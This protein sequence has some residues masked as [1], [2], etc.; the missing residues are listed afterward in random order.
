MDKPIPI[1]TEDPIKWAEYLESGNWSERLRVA[2]CLRQLA[3][4]LEY[5]QSVESEV[6]KVYLHVTSG[7]FQSPGTGAAYI[8]DEYEEQHRDALKL[9]EDA[10]DWHENYCD[11]DLEG[12]QKR[13]R[14]FLEPKPPVG[15]QTTENVQKAIDVVERVRNEIRNNG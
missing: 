10:A 14:A 3:A 11:E 15:T 4:K 5:H 1:M 2:A 9:L 7:K 6:S 8:I 13:I 12:L